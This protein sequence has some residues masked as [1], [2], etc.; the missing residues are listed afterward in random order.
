MPR[1]DINKLTKKELYKRYIKYSKKAPKIKNEIV[2]EALPEYLREFALELRKKRKEKCK[3]T[4][5]VNLDSKIYLHKYYPWCYKNFIPT[6]VLQGWYNPQIARKK[7]LDNYGPD[8]LK[9]VKFI[10]GKEALEMDFSIGKTL[11]INGKWRS[12]KHKIF[13]PREVRVN[14]RRKSY[15]KKFLMMINKKNLSSSKKDKKLIEELE[16]NQYGRKRFV[17]DIKF[18]ERSGVQEIQK[19]NS[20]RKKNLYQE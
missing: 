7:Y 19:I 18:N 10:R 11:Y 4:K 17:Q 12:V 1:V 16:Y 9:Y 5:L 20:R 13:F 14:H 3:S 2:I 15:K 8:S 6:L